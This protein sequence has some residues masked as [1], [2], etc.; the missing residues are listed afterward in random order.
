MPISTLSSFGRAVCTLGALLFAMGSAAQQDF[1]N[2]QIELV[3]PY[4]PGGGTDA[5]ARIVG[6]RLSELLKVPVVV[7]NKPGAA[8]AIGTSYVLGANDGYRIGA[9]G[10]SNLGPL[11]AI[12]PKPPYSLT[13][14]A[15]IAR[16]VVNPLVLVAKKDRFADFQ[17]FLKEAKEKPDSVTFGSWGN[18]SPAHIYGELFVQAT[19]A[20]LR[21]IPFDGGTKAMLSALAG[22]TDI[23]VVTIATAKGQLQ[24]GTLV[25]LAIT[26][27]SRHSD[28]PN[29]P[30]VGELGFREATYV[31]FDGFVGSAKAP[32]E[33]LA[34]LRSAFEKALNDPKVKEDLKKA[35][36]E[37]GYMDGPQ[38]EEF[39]RRNVDLQRRVAAR[40][41]IQE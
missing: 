37:P 31:T 26:A 21:H 5:M 13:E 39:M 32:K 17:A 41:G 7:V 8:G 2:R 35:G 4:G 12:G 38:Y 6:P 1:P 40:A 27:D 9:G 23:A 10:N 20:K 19:G 16:A 34:I 11:V 33:H 30:T 3:V 14:V 24:A 18:K 36:S 22:H 28:L 29:V 15:G 25:P